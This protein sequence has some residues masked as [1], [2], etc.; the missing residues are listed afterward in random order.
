MDLNA[1]L[2]DEKGQLKAEYTIEG[3]HMY[4]DGY[5]QV[6]ERLLPKLREI[7]ETDHKY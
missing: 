3:M 4:A 6:L 2:L 5:W 7:A 1:G